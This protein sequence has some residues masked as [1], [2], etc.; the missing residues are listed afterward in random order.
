M[1]LQATRTMTDTT[2]A[3]AG[4][5]LAT[6][7]RAR[8]TRTAPP[9][10]RPAGMLTRTRP[11]ALALLHARAVSHPAPFDAGLLLPYHPA[12]GAASFFAGGGGAAR[13]SSSGASFSRPLGLQRYH[14]Q[15]YRGICLRSD[16]DTEVDSLLGMQSMI[17]TVGSLVAG[18]VSAPWRRVMRAAT[19]EQ[20]RHAHSS[21]CSHR[22]RCWCCVCARA[23]AAARAVEG[24]MQR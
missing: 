24:R 21:A 3:Q 17:A 7:A 5:A 16:V 15:I 2:S 6:G 10:G 23:R 12:Y 18:A 13:P 9:A 8:Q 11:L 4:S 20:V 14:L 1:C 22:A 19:Y